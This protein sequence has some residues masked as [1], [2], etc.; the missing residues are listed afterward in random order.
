[1]ADSGSARRPLRR[2]VGVPTRQDELAAAA[3]GQGAGAGRW[4]RASSR[5]HP[6][7]AARS[8]LEVVTSASTSHRQVVVSCALPCSAS[9]PR[10]RDHGEQERVY[11]SRRPATRHRAG[12]QCRHSAIVP[13]RRS[14]HVEVGVQAKP[15]TTIGFRLDAIAKV[16]EDLF[17]RLVTGA[18]AAARQCR[19]AAWSAE[20]EPGGRRRSDRHDTRSGAQSGTAVDRGLYVR[21]RCLRLDAG[22]VGLLS[23]VIA[24]LRMADQGLV[25]SYPKTIAPIMAR[26]DFGAMF[27]MLSPADGRGMAPTRANRSSTSCSPRHGSPGWRRTTRC[28]RR[29]WPTR[30]PASARHRG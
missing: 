2:C 8:D 5:R 9:W 28:S 3:E 15:Q 6:S 11:P 26:T 16:L 10:Q 4:L 18:D 27:K 13:R 12:P 19:S 25:R 20:L 14:Q 22:T 21:Q 1:M 29:V 17:A 7:S 30:K 23:L 24:Y